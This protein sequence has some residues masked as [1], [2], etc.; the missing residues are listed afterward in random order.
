MFHVII[1]Y[2]RK[3]KKKLL[4]KDLDLKSLKKTFLKPY[5]SGNDFIV[6]NEIV[7]PKDLLFVQVVR[8]DE[9]HASVI[10]F[11][12]NKANKTP[13]I[14][15]L[16]MLIQ[17]HHICDYG[18]DVTAHYINKTAGSGTLFQKLIKFLHNPWL[19]RIGSG[20]ILLIVGIIVGRISTGL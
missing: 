1:S 2:E 4:Y 11:E 8:T 14:A 6:R 5:L 20:V 16:G 10:K 13:G 15:G 3:D 12:R 19:L 17:D 9:D 7:K 18:T